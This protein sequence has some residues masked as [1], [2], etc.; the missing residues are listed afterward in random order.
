[1]ASI[2]K[3]P[4]SQYWTACFRDLNAKQ[5]RVSTKTTDRKTAQ[6]L[7][8]EYE[9]AVRTKRTLRQAQV[10]LDR[11]HEEIS[12]VAVQRKTVRAYCAEWLATKE[13]ETAPRTQVFYRTSTA[14]F[15]A[16]L[17]ERADIPL[18]ELTKGDIVAY[19]NSLAK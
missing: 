8:D 10:V 4:L 2:W 3:H 14:K 12:G 1:M 16:F 18:S 6:R 7:A 19:R 9:A 15:I 5:R 11:L 17:G 13:P